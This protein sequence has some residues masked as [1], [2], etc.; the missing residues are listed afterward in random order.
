[1]ITHLPYFLCF[2]II[3][4]GIYGVAINGNYIKKL[5]SLG[6]MQSGVIMFFLALAK[7]NK[8][9]APILDCVDINQC[10]KLVANPLPQVLMLT[11]IV[12]GVATLAVG[13]SLVIKVKKTL[14]SIEENTLLNI[15]KNG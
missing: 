1:M 11:A 12:V 9:Y 4:V 10:P 15:D 14:G 8:A 2:A 7:V 5:I 13:L 3:L 6:I